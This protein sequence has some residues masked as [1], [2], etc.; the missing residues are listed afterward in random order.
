MARNGSVSFTLP[1]H[2][3]LGAPLI[4]WAGGAVPSVQA[5]P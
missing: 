5:V 2:G 3:I 1:Q 4:A